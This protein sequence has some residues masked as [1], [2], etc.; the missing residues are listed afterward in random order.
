MWDSAKTV[1]RGKFI[2]TNAYIRKEERSQ[3]S[4]LTFHLKE[5]EKEGQMKTKINRKK[6]IV[7]NRAEIE[8]GN[9]IEKMNKTK[10]FFRRPVKLI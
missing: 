5:P 8:N 2:A 10:V 4:D 7:K 6:E 9:A 3:I 1:L